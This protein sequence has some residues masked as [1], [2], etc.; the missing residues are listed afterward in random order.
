MTCIKRDYNYPRNTS[1]IWS[2]SFGIALD[3]SRAQEYV[4]G[5]PYLGRFV[6]RLYPTRARVSSN[7]TSRRSQ[8]LHLLRFI[9]SFFRQRIC[10]ADSSYPGIFDFYLHGRT[11][12]TYLRK[13]ALASYRGIFK[14]GHRRAS[15]IDS[16]SIKS[17]DNCII[18]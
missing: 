6:G 10:C 11:S 13:G 16:L 2:Q 7:A 17:T 15:R 18:N 1:I 12:K 5:T 14:N 9:S 3:Y 8:L 4:P